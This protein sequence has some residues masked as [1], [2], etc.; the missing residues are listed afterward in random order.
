MKMVW[1]VN[2]KFRFARVHKPDRHLRRYEETDTLSGD[3]A[4]PGFS[5]QISALLP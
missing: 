5:I 2:P 1:E 3:P 4:L